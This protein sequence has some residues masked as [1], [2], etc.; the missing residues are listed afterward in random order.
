[1]SS[2]QNSSSSS[3]GAAHHGATQGRSADWLMDVS[4]P[5]DAVLGVTTSTVAEC[6]RLAVGSIIRL[7]QAAGSDLELRVGGV[8]FAAGEVVASDDGLS[9][10]VGRVLAPAPEAFA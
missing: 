3:N 4:C 8:P 1:M 5:I 7:R 6:S 10:R 2:S 9:I